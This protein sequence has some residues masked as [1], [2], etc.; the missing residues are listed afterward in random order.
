MDASLQHGEGDRSPGWLFPA[1]A[2]GLIAAVAWGERRN[3][4]RAATV[5]REGPRILTNLAMAGMTAMVT[6]TAMAPVAEPLSEWAKTREVGLVQS[7]P[8]SAAVRDALA[9][10]LLDYTLY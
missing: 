6:Q 7:L 9:I 1:I 4:L 5:D 10:V 3:R 2:L 8:V